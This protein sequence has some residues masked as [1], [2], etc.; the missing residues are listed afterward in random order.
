M[1]STAI[2]PKLSTPELL[3]IRARQMGLQPAW[4]L[5]NGLFAIIIHGQERY[6]NFA[7]S[8]LNSHTSASLAKNKYITR[9]ILE[10]HH[11]QNIPF[12][13]P[14]SYEAAALFLQTH[15][16]IIAKPIQGAGAHDIHIVVTSAE[17][18]GFSDGR[19]IL[20]KYIAGIELRYLVLNGKVIGVHRSDYGTSVAETRPLE[21]ISYLKMHWNPKL[22]TASLQVAGILGLKFAAVDFLIDAKGNPYILEV[23]TT[24][25]LKWFHAP[26]AGP[27][28]D[29]AGQFLEAITQDKPT[30]STRVT[31]SSLGRHPI[32][33]YS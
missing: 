12:L 9:L 21:R 29:V 4:I 11:M 17:L 24:P 7:R 19:Y 6:I 30:T 13:L 2:S 26:T 33:V 28:I 20:E 16:K 10:R 18:Q 1:N 15:G 32:K 8:P 5:P 31:S 27:A 25:G 22:V 23:N 3:Y 14:E